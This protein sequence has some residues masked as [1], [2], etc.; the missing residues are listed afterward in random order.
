MKWR[1]SNIPIPEVHLIGLIVG[2]V[3]Q[4]VYP[5][6][7]TAWVWLRY[8]VGSLAIVTGILFAWW[9]VR[10][11]AKMDIAAPSKVLTKGPYAY[12]RNPMYVGWT[13]MIAG[14]ALV[15]NNLWMLLILLL[16][17]IYTHFFVILKEEHFLTGEF[18]K[19]Y[20]QYKTKVK[21]YLF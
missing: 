21:R 18:G 6:E 12:S 14:I 20:E 2:V 10:T 5:L 1:W 17:V 16:V 13:L 3:I 4:I 7:F 19:E 11:A 8:L 9:A 15:M